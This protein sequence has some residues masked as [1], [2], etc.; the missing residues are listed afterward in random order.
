MKKLKL[1][2]L[3][4]LFIGLASCN[5]QTNKGTTADKKKSPNVVSVYYFHGSN[6]CAGC[7]GAENGTVQALKDLYSKEMEEGIIKYQAINIEE[8]VN[9]KIAEKYSIVFSSLII[10]KTNVEKEKVVNLTSEAFAYGKSEPEKL[11]KIIKTNIDK[12]LTDK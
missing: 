11:K 1:M 8:E 6:R 7:I 12:M 5:G 3:V 10:V 4:F 9:K 2:V